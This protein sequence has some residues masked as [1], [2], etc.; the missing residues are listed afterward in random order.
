MFNLNEAAPC[1]IYDSGV[2][3]SACQQLKH[4]LPGFDFLYSIKANPFEPVV[5]CISEE[6]F[7][8]DAASLNEVKKSCEFGIQSCDIFY[9]APGKQEEDIRGAW[10]QCTLIADSLHEIG[11]IQRVASSRN[12]R[13]EI[14]LRVHPAIGMDGEASGS[15]KFGIDLEDMWAL[16]KTLSAC[17]S[18]IPIGIHVHMKSQVL[19]ANK[20]TTYWLNVMKTALMLKEELGMEMRFINFGSGIGTVYN[21]ELEQPVDLEELTKGVQPVYELNRELRARLLV[22]TGRYVIC[23]AG[24]YITPVVD[25]KVSH[26]TTYLIVRNG[27][28]GFMRPAVAAMLNRVAAGSYIPAME[29]LFTREKEFSVRVLNEN[30]EQETVTVVGNLCTAM[31]II[32]ENICLNKAEIGDLIEITNAGSY[33]YSLSPLMFSSHD[34]PGEYLV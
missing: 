4:S 17:P 16:Q 19:D 6:G 31:D 14:G 5:R 8:A 25:R 20:L 28:N 27:L 29:P 13:V 34:E 7:G 9:S 18:V 10:G 23:R 26:G 32:A 30:T 1:Y 22:E 24:R 11:M 33:A 2:I 15:S 21:P 12:E 3:R